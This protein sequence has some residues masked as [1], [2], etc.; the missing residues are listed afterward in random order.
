MIGVDIE[1]NILFNE[2]CSV[3]VNVQIRNY[4]RNVRNYTHEYTEKNSK[5]KSLLLD[6]YFLNRKPC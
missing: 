2:Q 4:A 3:H 6:E 5:L 1:R